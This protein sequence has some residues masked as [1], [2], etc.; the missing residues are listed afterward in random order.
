MKACNNVEKHN[1]LCSS[2][3][4]LNLSP[5]DSSLFYSF[6]LFWNWQDDNYFNNFLQQENFW[7]FVLIWFKWCH[8][9]QL[10]CIW[11]QKFLITVQ[12]FCIGFVIFCQE[13]PNIWKELQIFWND[14]VLSCK[15]MKRFWKCLQNSC[16][17]FESNL[18]GKIF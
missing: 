7:L 1:L 6:F 8:S 2:S 15:N 3:G 9:L 13:T 11:T 17:G 12:K 10:F 16:T 14:S 18:Y 4:N 5:I